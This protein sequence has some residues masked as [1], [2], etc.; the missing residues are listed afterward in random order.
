MKHT[1]KTKGELWK[2][3]AEKA[4]WFFITIPKKLS[5]DLKELCEK[6]SGWGSIR[7]EITI[8]NSSWKTSL[9]PNKTG[10]YILPVKK[11][12]REAENIKEGDLVEITFINQ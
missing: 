4:S 1:F 5:A 6:S 9:F 7:V 2:W 8:G 3:N 10:E 12:I 11:A